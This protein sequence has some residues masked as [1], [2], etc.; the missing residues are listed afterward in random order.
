MAKQEA[1]NTHGG[2]FSFHTSFKTCCSDLPMSAC[3]WSTK[4]EEREM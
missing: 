2:D 4:R 3:L 1:S